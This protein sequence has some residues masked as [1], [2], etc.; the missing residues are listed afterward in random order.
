MSAVSPSGSTIRD[1]ARVAGVSLGTVSN[2]LNDVK[3]ISPK[4]RVRI[5]QAIENLEFVPNRALRTMHG[6]RSP[7]IGFVVSDSPDPFFV[8]VARGVEDVI[9]SAGIV[10]VSCNT[11]GKQEYESSYVKVLAEMR[12]TGAIVMPSF[13]HSDVPFRGLR[14]SGAGLVVLG[15]WDDDTCAISFDDRLGGQLAIEHLIELGHTDIVFLGGPGGEH[16]IEQRYLG[17]LTALSP[18]SPD[19]SLRR[20][21]AAGVTVQDRAFLADQVLALDPRPTAIFAASDTL[22]L[23][24]LNE[25]LRRDIRVPGEMAVVGFNNIAAAQ[26]AVVPLTTVSVPQ[27]EMGIRAAQ[28]LLDELRPGHVHQQL[29]LKPNLIVRESTRSVATPGLE[30]PTNKASRRRPQ[31]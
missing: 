27:Y 6:G 22:A 29:L 30:G 4:T 16:Q 12:V 19:A 17:A 18:F 20:V 13:E 15:E 23:A 3:P 24:V 31:D 25:L 28:L 14:A 5:E 8:E 11:K 7:A 2:Y 9:R 21:D 1:V 10:L 26:L